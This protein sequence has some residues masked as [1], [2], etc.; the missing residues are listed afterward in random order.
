[1]TSADDVTTD[2]LMTLVQSWRLSPTK[3]VTCPSCKTGSLTIL[4]QSS[5]PYREWY[6]TSC[7]ACG[8]K[9]TVAISLGSMG[10]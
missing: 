9:K 4:D 2:E 1:M 6:A 3:P 7:P 5:R 8:F 10:G